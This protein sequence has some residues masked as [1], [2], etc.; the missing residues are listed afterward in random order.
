MHILSTFL[1]YVFQSMFVSYMSHFGVLRTYQMQLGVRLRRQWSEDRIGISRV[2]SV[3]ILRTGKI[4]GVINVSAVET[5]LKRYSA[6]LSEVNQREDFYI[7]VS[8]Q[9]ATERQT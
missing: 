4:H 7:K 2:A 6:L 1:G 5:A 9:T 3:R 8:T